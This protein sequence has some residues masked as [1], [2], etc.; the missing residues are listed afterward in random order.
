LAKT[1]TA[2]PKMRMIK[3]CIDGMIMVGL[4]RDLIEDEDT[5]S[6]GLGF[7]LLQE[8]RTDYLP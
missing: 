3:R 6:S 2:R 5:A 1:A 4:V 8:G 7:M